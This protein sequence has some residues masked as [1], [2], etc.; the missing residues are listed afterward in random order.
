MSLSKIN[1]LAKEVLDIEAKSILRLKNNI[2]EEFDKAIDI[3]YNCKG[4]VIVTGMGKSGLIG[5]KIAA[6]MSST[7]TPT[8]FLHPAESTHGDSGVITRNDVIIAISNSGETQEL[9]N[10]LPLI[11]RF[12][13]EMIGMTGNL[14]STL[15]KTSEVVLDISVEREA[16]PLGKAPTAS[17][18]A[19]LAMGD[20]LAVCLMEKKGFTKED[21]LLFHPSG[22]LGKGLTYKVRDLMITGDKMPLVSESESF[23]D[24]IN[25]ISEY[26]L[27]MAMVL[28]DDK[29]LAGVLTDGDI[30]RTVIKYP[31][32]SNIKVKDVMTVN[33]KRITSDAYAASALNLMEK[34]SITALAV[35]DE[36]NVPVGVIHVHDLLRAGVA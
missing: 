7:G 5:K 12:G 13:C 21:F 19:T 31:D 15:S 3:L 22:K 35:V 34:Y 24:V 2:G 25:T 36:G 9:L 33:P 1:E 8:Y 18:T 11:K 10:L 26:K 30:R 23:K 14:N 27:G 4:R 16:C 28:N 29:T 6:T 20:A 17:T 32:T